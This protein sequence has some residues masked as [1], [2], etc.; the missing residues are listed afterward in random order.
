[1]F[2]VRNITVFCL[3]LLFSACLQDD[4]ELPI[5]AEKAAEILIDVHAAEA[6]LQNVYGSKKDTLAKVYYQ[7]IY[8]VHEIDSTTFA[9]LM[10]LVRNYPK[11][12]KEVYGLAMEQI[13]SRREASE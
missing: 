8:E 7:Q 6:A 2:K 10:E 13:K 3:F 1:M 4:P 9:E 5:P 12:L 11:H